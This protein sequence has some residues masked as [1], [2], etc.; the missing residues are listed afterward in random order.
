M[1]TKICTKCG[2]EKELSNFGKNGKYLRPDCKECNNLRNIKYYD[3]HKEKIN[4]NHRNHYKQNKEE[5]SKR[6]IKYNSKRRI[7]D[8]SFKILNNFRRRL[9][10]ALDGKIK[11]SSSLKLLGCTPEQLKQHLESQFIESMSWDNYGLHG[12]HIDHKL[13][14]AKFDLSKEQEQLECFHYT[15]LQPLWTEENWSKG[16]K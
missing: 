10:R 8:P 7:K 5:Y 15:N 16:S 11:I 2:I 13:P 3:K 6:H 4:G 1:K 12:W 14:C 9:L